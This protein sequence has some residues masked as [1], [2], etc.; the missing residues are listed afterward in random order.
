ML[1]TETKLFAVLGYPIK[2]S[3]S[4]VMQNKWF[5][6][7]KYNCAYLSFEIQPGNLKKAL[8]SFKMLGF[9]GLNIT[10][11]HKTEVIKYLDYSD[12]AAKSIG[13]ANTIAIRN[14]KL[15]G[16]NTDHSGF[17]A[18]LITKGVKVRNKTV[19][20]YG[21][22]GA[23][24]AVIYAVKNAEAK[25]IYITNRTYKKAEKLAKHFRIESVQEEN[26]AEIMSKADLI[27]NTSACGMKKSDVLPFKAGTLK[28]TAVVYDLIYN[29]KTPFT[30]LAKENRIEYYSGEGMLINQG[31]HAFKI[32]TGI[33]PNT[34]STLK[35]LKKFMR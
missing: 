33:Y 7:E 3:F 8:D 29:K 13:S 4:P 30:K 34:K 22:G 20:I 2:H 23:S 35:L 1:N 11:P 9:Y 10:I 6:K 18:D 12:K 21:A 24:R 16:Y 17:S 32:W 5:E 31:A 15:Y 14:G 28:K 19:F 27:I 25:K 26:A